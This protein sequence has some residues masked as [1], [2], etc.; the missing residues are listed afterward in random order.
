MSSESP[1]WIALIFSIIAITISGLSWW[2]SRQNRIINQEVNRPILKV[3]GVSLSKDISPVV[4]SFKKETG[5]IIKGSAFTTTVWFKVKIANVG[6]STATLYHVQIE[7]FIPPRI[8]S[9]FE[10]NTCKSEHPVFSVGAPGIEMV[11]GSEES[12]R[13]S[14]NLTKECDSLT[15][16]VSCLVTYSDTITA[17]Q[18]FQTLVEEV[19]LSPKKIPLN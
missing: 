17:R 1:K 7:S 9:P 12:F 10:E 2:E 11:P 4:G 3:A 18:Y 14:V 16:Y 13:G 15:V 19:E 8:G 6:K 5:I